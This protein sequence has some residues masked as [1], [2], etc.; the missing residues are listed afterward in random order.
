M[1]VRRGRS[2]RSVRSRFSRNESAVEDPLIIQDPPI[3][4]VDSSS[5]TGPSVPADPPVT[6]D[7]PPVRASPAASTEPTAATSTIP[8]DPGGGIPTPV[9]TPTTVT[10][11]VMQMLQQAVGAQ[12]GMIARRL[13]LRGC[14][15]LELAPLR[16][17]LVGVRVV[18]RFCGRSSTID[19][20]NSR[21]GELDYIV[22]SMS[23]RRGRSYRSVRS[24]FIR[25]ESA[26][27]DPPIIQD[28]PIP[29]VDSSSSTGPSVPAD[30]PVTTD[31][32]PV[33]ASPAAP[34]EP[35]VATSTIPPGPGGGIPTP[36]VT[37]TAVTEVV[38][39]MLQ[40]DV[41]AQ[42]GMIVQKTVSERLRDIGARSFEGVTR[43]MTVLAED[44]LEG[45]KRKLDELQCTNEQKLRGIVSLLEGEA[46][47]WWQYVQSV[48]HASQLT[49]DFFC[50]SFQ[51]KYVGPAYL[52]A[53]RKQ[54]MDLKQ[55]NMTVT[56]YETEFLN[57]SHYASSIIPTEEDKSQKRGSTSVSSARPVKKA[58]D[59]RSEFSVTGSR[60]VAPY[61]HSSADER[62]YGS[63][64]FPLC[65]Y[66]N[67]VHRGECRLKSEGC[68]RCGSTDHRLRDCPQPFRSFPAA[69]RSQSSVQAPYRGGH[70]SGSSGSGR[71]SG[72]GTHSNAQSSARSGARQPCLVYATRRREDRD[73]PDVI[74]GTFTVRSL[75]YFALI[76]VGSTYSCVASS[77]S[78]R[79]GVTSEKTGHGVTVLSPLGHSVSV[80]RIFRRC[81]LEIQDEVFPA[82]LM[83][84]PFG[85]FDLILG[86]DWLTEHQANLDCPTRKATLK[87]VSGKDVVLTGTRRGFMT[88]VILVLAAGRKI[89]KGCEAFLAFILDAKKFDSDLSNIQTVQDFPKVFSEELP[90][91]FGYKSG[92][93][94]TLP[95]RYGHYEFLVMPFGL[96]NA[97]AKFM[98]LMNRVFQPY[99]DQFVVVFIDDILVY[100]R[101]EAEHDD[102]LR[103][104]LQ[105]LKDNRLYTKLSK[106]EFWLSEVTF[107]G[108]VVSADGQISFKKLK[109]VLT[110]APIL[111]QPESEKDFV[112]Y[113][114][115]SHTGL[116]C[117]LMPDERVVA[118]ASRQLKTH[119]RNYPTH[120]LELATVVFALKIWRHYLYGERCHIYT[121]HK[122]LK[123]L[124]S[125]KELNMRR[126]RWLELL[127]DYDCVID[128]HPGKA[129]VVADALSLKTVVD[130]K[131]MFARLSLFDDG[132][133][134]VELQVKP[135][136]I[137][138][139]KAKRPLDPSFAS[140]VRLIEQGSVDY[141]FD[142]NGVVC[143]RG[144]FWVPHDADLR[145]TILWE[146]HGSPYTVHPGGN[147]MYRD[148]R[149]QYWW[150]GMKCDLTSWED[151]LPLVEFVYSNSFQSSIQMAPYEALYGRRCRTTLGWIGL[152]ERRVLGP[153]IV[154]QTEDTVRVIRDRLK[155]AFDQQ[156][157]CDDLKRKEIEFS[158]GDQVFLKVSP[159]K[160]VLRFGRKGKLSLRFIGPY[161]IAWRVGPV[162]YSLELPPELQRIHDVFHVSMLRR[163]RSDPSHVIPT[164]EIEVRPDL[165]YEEEPIQILA[166][167]EK[168]LRSKTISM[169]K[170]LWNNHGSSEA[171]W[172]WRRP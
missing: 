5:S 66:C 72:R 64:E 70:S 128:Y 34:T 111:V 38:M 90:S 31:P 11:V 155:A 39:Q 106:C 50:E 130:L 17:L 117:V 100:S 139:I 102:H 6:T 151:H 172:S 42:S 149:S 171:T 126:R 7:P 30:P 33:R 27:E 94:Y 135:T 95:T 1:S 152:S 105:T 146:S 144:K 122:S 142:E 18:I 40:Q 88:N 93:G 148:L 109:S 98:D 45:V 157:A 59:D 141:S 2:H 103:I 80:N 32:P 96:T 26:V 53:R 57:L 92:V 9:V 47:R 124:L 91:V 51:R 110:Q 68:F 104:V 121:D 22:T 113:S 58:R 81:P 16:A 76:D 153:E 115:A 12:S 120:D 46:F 75:P 77:V 164:E 101:S 86:M 28:P 13:F 133:L 159:W 63:T 43:S 19:R 20:N 165:S 61:R 131:A 29:R 48:T 62:I 56:K 37:P 123:Y 74:V 138:E 154:Q 41:G 150:K 97:P 71:T 156:K 73:E 99:L 82:D 169:V 127:K 166:H 4:R 87:I 108:H 84:L 25:N 140:R 10:E 14:G 49:W 114:D 8:P 118:Y 67:R 116:G 89:E 125:Q 134:L 24:R 167:D 162:A 163:Y 65:T 3:Q 83:E 78:V 147:K 69:S 170:V 36:V 107:L 161:R 60:S 54:F 119:E 168:V 21:F 44:W 23:V 55:N 52:A 136:L 132:N 145:Q 35:T 79:L 85:E 158:V 15:I 160:K 143:Y 137:D 129:S 112:V